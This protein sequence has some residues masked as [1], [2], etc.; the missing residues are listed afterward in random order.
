[1]KKI[2]ILSCFLCLILLVGN[3]SVTAFDDGASVYVERCPHC[4][5]GMHT[6][7]VYEYE[8]ISDLSHA[9]IRI[10]LRECNSCDYSYENYRNE[11]YEYHTGNPC[12]KCPYGH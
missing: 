2:R 11:T 8:E 7:L 12:S 1:M 4:E 9:V 10:Y 6:R 5:D 3:L